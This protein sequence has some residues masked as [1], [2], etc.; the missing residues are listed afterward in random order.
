MNKLGSGKAN[1]GSIQQ[2]SVE[3]L[4]PRMAAFMLDAIPVG[5]MYG[6]ALGVLLSVSSI[7]LSLG[8]LTSLTLHFYA[9]SVLAGLYHAP[10]E[11]LFGG[12]LGK[13]ASGIRVIDGRTH[14][15][16]DLSAALTRNL[17]RA[18]DA[19]F[20]YLPALVVSTSISS[21]QRFGDYAAGT[22]VVDSDF[23]AHVEEAESLE[24]RKQA[25]A[26]AEQ[27]VSHELG[28]LAAFDGDYYVWDD[29][30]EDGVGNID[31]LVVGPGGATIVETKS[32]RG[33]VGV[34]DRGQPTVDGKPLERNVLDQVRNQR[35]A[36][37]SR[38]GLDD[39][40]PDKV[41]GFNWLICFPRG[42]LANGLD[43]NVRRRLA[44]TRDLRGKIRSQP[45]TATPGQVLSMAWA[46]E[47]LYGREPNHSPSG[48]G[49][50]EP[51]GPAQA[52]KRPR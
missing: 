13:L 7:Q 43:P 44:T 5:I 11:A 41:A 46:I 42:E 33:V 40:D 12:S 9:A 35:R 52:R 19:P 28:K 29:L 45:R 3:M 47:G 25:G 2:R 4:K 37:V 8:F 27:R 18:V 17:L 16:P 30:Y 31:H 50:E 15:K 6:L 38:M 10:L 24:R 23:R 39:T 48:P 34:E 26:R 32:H 22:L 14:G 20:Y 1:S 36:V 51:D 49:E 21:R